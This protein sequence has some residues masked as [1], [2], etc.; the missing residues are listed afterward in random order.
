MN[1]CEMVICFILQVAK[2]RD[3]K[4]QG[5]DLHSEIHISVAQAVL[6]GTI[7]I[8]GVYEEILLN[9]RFITGNLDIS[10]INNLYTMLINT[11]D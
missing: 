6:G 8:P 1:I 9:V 7:R 10:F 11:K 4:R 5:A 2:S 3:F